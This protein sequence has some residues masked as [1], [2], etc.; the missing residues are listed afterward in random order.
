MNDI[1]GGWPHL[2]EN[3]MTWQWREGGRPR[4]EVVKGAALYCTE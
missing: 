2:E 4:G 1:R 3:L